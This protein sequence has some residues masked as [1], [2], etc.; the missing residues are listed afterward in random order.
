VEI[1]HLSVF[2]AAF[3][4]VR[5]SVGVSRSLVTRWPRELFAEEFKKSDLRA[6]NSGKSFAGRRE[7]SSSERTMMAPDFNC[8]L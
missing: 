5:F 4:E 8:S 6:A 2:F 1:T 3:R 7:L